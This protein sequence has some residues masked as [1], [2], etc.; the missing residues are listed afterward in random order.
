MALSG[1]VGQDESERMCGSDFFFFQ[2]EDGIRDLTVTGVQTCALPICTQDQSESCFSMGTP[3][4]TWRRHP[5]MTSAS[6]VQRR[7]RLRGTRFSHSWAIGGEIGRGACR[8][9]GEISVGAGFFKKKK[10]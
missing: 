2:A 7:T 4:K 3:S 9:R 8:G 10:K 1:W 6:W 5:F